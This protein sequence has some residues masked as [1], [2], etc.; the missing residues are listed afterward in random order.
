MERVGQARVAGTVAT[1][2]F[3]AQELNGS[4]VIN[5][6]RAYFSE[7]YATLKQNVAD[8]LVA[9]GRTHAEEVPATFE[10][11]VRV[12]GERRQ[13]W[14]RFCD[15]P[16]I[17]LDTAAITLAWRSARNAALAQLN[18]KQG[19][20]LDRMTLTDQT[21]TAIAAYETQ[22]QS[23]AMKPSYGIRSS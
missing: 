4:P 6:Y 13:F 8:T 14:F 2:P 18:A 21:R 17:N 9:I 23:V 15:I 22:R 16:D 19:A 5:H 1:C 7:A 10:R 3:C 12:A 11:A 20:P